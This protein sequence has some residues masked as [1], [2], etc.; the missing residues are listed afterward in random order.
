MCGAAF[1]Q[2]FSYDRHILYKHTENAQ[3]NHKCNICDKSF[4]TKS[5][6]SQHLKSKT[7][8]GPGF[9]ARSSSSSGDP[10]KISNSTNSPPKERPPGASKRGKSTSLKQ[11]GVPTSIAKNVNIYCSDSG[12]SLD[13]SQNN[14]V[15]PSSDGSNVNNPTEVL[16]PTMSNENNQAQHPS[17]HHNPNLVQTSY[18]SM[19]FNPFY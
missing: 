9:K 11:K 12:G 8:G 3:K 5:L 18:S 19:I 10:N 14:Y 2:R 6:L 13:P 16:S 15:N 17:H 4:L 1:S 7:H